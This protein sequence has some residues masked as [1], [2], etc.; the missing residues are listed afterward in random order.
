MVIGYE[1]CMVSYHIIYLSIVVRCH[2]KSREAREAMI[3][4]VFGRE[5]TLFQGNDPIR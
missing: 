3:G 1:M 5:K 4:R 2:C